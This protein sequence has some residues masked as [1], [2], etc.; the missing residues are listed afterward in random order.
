MQIWTSFLFFVLLSFGLQA[1]A[2]YDIKIKANN[3]DYDTLVIGYKFGKQQYIKDTLVSSN[4][5]DFHFTGQDTLKDGMY[6]IVLKPKN[7]FLEF[8]VD[9]GDHKFSM[10]FDNKNLANSLKFKG[11]KSNKIFTEYTGFLKGLRPRAVKLRS[12][13]KL[14]DSL[15]NTKAK[16]KVTKEL[17]GMDKEVKEY[18]NTFIRKHA[19][20]LPALIVKA[21]KEPEMPEFEGDK[22]DVQQK[23]YYYFRNHFFDNLDLT[24]PRLLYT[25]LLDRKIK[26]YINKVVPQHPD[27][28]ST[29]LDKLLQK[30]ETNEELYKYY[31]IDFLNE[32]A[33][34]K[35]VGFDA[36][37][38]HLVK[39]YYEKGKA[40]WVGA[41]SMAK[42]V[43]D[44]SLLFPVLIGKKAP[45]ITLYEKD[46]TPKS[47]YDVDKDFTV[48]FFWAPDCGHCK[49][50]A[51]HLVKFYNQFKDRVSVITI[52]NDI[53]NEKEEKTWKAVEEHKFD[54]LINLADF[55][56]TS[57]FKTKYNIKST[58]TIYI[59]NKDK[60][61]IMKRIPAK[62]L[63]EV[64]EEL[65]RLDKK[66]RAKK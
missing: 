3:Y 54:D 66:K 18:Q 34:S 24:D 1:Q 62:D 29:E 48:L 22:K 20:T 8:L 44:A 36:I 41:E 51:P 4:K 47:V 52:G 43:R 5:Q 21:L 13:I 10:T 37:Y 12:E 57:R 33:G 38:V 31:L 26:Y 49:K 27:T 28:I 7:D 15:G 11:S 60:E 32:Y 63:P 61:I 65:I 58:P 45:N 16:D 46:G 59:L 19:G 25:N 50:S 53:G 39:N 14:Q 6:I 42:I 40:P 35:V 30:M 23:Q 9:K 55:K 17:N 56:Y 64:M 2:G